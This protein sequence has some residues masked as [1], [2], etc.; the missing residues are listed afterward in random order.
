MVRGRCGVW[1]VVVLRRGGGGGEC[2]TN[3]GNVSFQLSL[4]CKMFLLVRKGLMRVALLVCAC[5]VQVTGTYGK[6]V[7]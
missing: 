3:T 1:V 6:V 4:A 7:R 5:F 2:G